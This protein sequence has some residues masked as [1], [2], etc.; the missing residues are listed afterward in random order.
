VGIPGFH[1]SRLHQEAYTGPVN[2]YS[3]VFNNTGEALKAAIERYLRSYPKAQVHILRKHAYALGFWLRA[4]PRMTS[5]KRFEVFV[6][7]T[8]YM[9]NILWAIFIGLIL[10]ATGWIQRRFSR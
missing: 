9:P 5:F 4:Y 3:R 6:S 1:Y 8:F 2:P 7:R 10:F